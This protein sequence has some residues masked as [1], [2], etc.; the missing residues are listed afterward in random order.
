MKRS[1]PPA[2]E[3]APCALL[4]WDTEFWGVPI[5][6][7]EGEELDAER[8]RA[9][10]AWADANGIACLYFLAG[11]DAATGHVAEA[12]GFRLMDCAPS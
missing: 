2:A 8:L 10:D 1:V 7:V 11:P 4:P 3:T 9:V 12:G 6:R 5:G